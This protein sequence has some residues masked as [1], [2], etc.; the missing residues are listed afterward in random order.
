VDGNIFK[1]NLTVLSTIHSLYIY[2]Y[3]GRSLY[4]KCYCLG[5][6]VLTSADNIYGQKTS[7][8]CFTHLLGLHKL[9]NMILR[10][11]RIRESSGLFKTIWADLQHPAPPP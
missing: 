1:D 7:L 5:I 8:Q 6:N 10:Q 9:S 2:L 11:A 3:Q 4:L